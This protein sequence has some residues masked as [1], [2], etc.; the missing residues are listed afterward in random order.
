MSYYAESVVYN[1][2]LLRE[3]Y[4]KDV[5]E[6]EVLGEGAL[7]GLLPKMETF[8]G[9]DLPIPMIFGNPQGGSATLSVA[10]ANKSNS[11]EASFALKRFKD[12]AVAS[13]ERE[14][15]LASEIDKDKGAWMELAKVA[16]DGALNTAT[17][18]LCVS[19]YRDG[20]G[21]RGQISS[22][23]NTGSATI[24]LADINDITNFEV[25]MF[26]VV[27]STLFNGTVRTGQAQITSVDRN[28]GT[29]TFGGNLTSY[30]AAAAAGDYIFRAGD[31]NLVTPGLLAWLVP[32]S[33]R[34]TAA[35]QD[36][37]FTQ[38]R[39][40]DMTRMMG[41]YHNGTQQPIE[42]AM[43]DLER[44]C[45]REGAKVTH[46]FMNNVQYGQMLKALVGKVIYTPTVQNARNAEGDV[47]TV[48]FSGIEFQGT[49]GLVKVFA[50][51]YCPSTKMFALTLDKWKLY[52]LGPAPHIF[53][54]DNDQEFL[55]DAQNDSYEVRTGSYACLGCRAVGW[56]G[57]AD[58]A[59]AA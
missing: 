18:S 2:Q 33:L 4:T 5:V 34:P 28:A 14:A 44:K 51:P 53:D 52:S 36:S 32:P 56:N 59:A 7:F 20:S 17:K 3:Y 47:A 15:K 54:M 55:R 29:L 42:E 50:D 11:Q 37:F 1:A 39:F 23:S 21:R 58:L 12:Y 9:K 49:G 19:L 41:I 10:I 24:T 30:I 13:I 27:C 22:S 48:S 45:H 38:D 8:S 46:I 43:I 31:Y 57:Q 26:I 16:L 25:N 40:A 6:N 35:G